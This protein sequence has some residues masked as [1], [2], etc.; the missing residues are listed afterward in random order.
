MDIIKPMEI[1]YITHNTKVLMAG[2]I[3]PPFIGIDQHGENCILWGFAGQPVVVFFYPGIAVPGCE[4]L[5]LNFA[6]LHEAFS[7]AGCKVIAIGLDNIDVTKHIASL[8]SIAY[9]MLSAQNLQG[10]NAE[11]N[12]I[13]KQ[14]GATKQ[15]T[16]QQDKIEFAPYSFMIDENSRIRKISPI[17]DI[18]LHPQEVLRDLQ[19]LLPPRE[20]REVSSQAPVLFIDNVLTTEECAYLIHVWDTQGN[21]DSGS[22]RTIEGKTV[23]VYNYDT[24]IR[25]DHFISDPALLTHLDMIMRRRIFPQIQKA[26]HFSCT[27]RE[28]Y[29]I[30]CYDSERGGYFRRHRDNTTAATAHRIWAMS[31]NLN[32]DQYEG[33]HLK[34][35]EFSDY[36]YKPKTGSA[37]IFSGSMM[38]EAT[39]VSNGKRFVLLQFF[40]GDKEA[41]IRDKNRHLLVGNDTTTG[42]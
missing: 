1:Q 9:P 7:K 25:R 14:Y 17:T 24:K 13:I 33:G 21:V 15:S 29:K 4:Q 8:Y 6:K 3:A 41:E 39:D 22:M 32:S 27:R 36:H 38:H 11:G 19:T 35:P 31:L 26:F 20:S 40:Y 23:G 30:A 12:G 18:T 28:E 34:F 16:Q 42:S 10:R 5:L 37:L 2:D